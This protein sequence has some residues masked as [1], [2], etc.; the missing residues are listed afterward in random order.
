M[1]IVLSFRICRHC[2]CHCIETIQQQS[3][4]NHHDW[5]KIHKIRKKFQGLKTIFDFGHAKNVHFS[6]VHSSFRKNLDFL[7]PYHDGHNFFQWFFV[8]GHKSFQSQGSIWQGSATDC[9]QKAHF[10]DFLIST[11]D[12]KTIMRV[13]LV[14]KCRKLWSGAFSNGFVN[15]KAHRNPLVKYIKCAQLTT[16]LWRIQ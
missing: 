1:I 5:L 6:K 11:S 9:Q 7:N 8:Y 4:I 14:D 12:N 13:N 16:N 15:Q 3:H 2:Y 10:L